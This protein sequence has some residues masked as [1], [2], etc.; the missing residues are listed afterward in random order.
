M[1]WI[2]KT[3]ILIAAIAFPPDFSSAFLFFLKQTLVSCRGLKVG[4]GAGGAGGA[5]AGARDRELVWSGRWSVNKLHLRLHFAG[6]RYRYYSHVVRQYV[7][8]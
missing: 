8:L 2:L 4:W 1:L 3:R 5:G 6:Y 7:V